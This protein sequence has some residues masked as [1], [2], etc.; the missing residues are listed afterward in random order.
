[1]S[2]E[3]NTP[4][5]QVRDLS[6]RFGAKE[7]VRGVGFDIVPLEARSPRTPG[8]RGLGGIRRAAMP[9]VVASHVVDH[10]MQIAPQPASLLAPPLL[11]FPISRHVPLHSRGTS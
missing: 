5:L 6:V 4:L 11:T 3:A 10:H 2:S 7:V 9:R 1:M 8:D